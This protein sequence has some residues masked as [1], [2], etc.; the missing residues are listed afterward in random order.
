MISVSDFFET[1]GYFHAKGIFDSDELVGLEAEYNKIIQQLLN[2][3]EQID[4]K[5]DG[6]E[7]KNLAR[8][9]DVILH[10]HNVQK[11]SAVWSKAFYQ[12]KLLFCQHSLKNPQ[13]VIPEECPK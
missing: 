9:E 11:Y 1:H 3:G 2:S 7:M 6:S 5:W 10:T 13:N 8:R 4:A 12:K